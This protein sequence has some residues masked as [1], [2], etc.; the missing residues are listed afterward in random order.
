ME[1]PAATAGVRAR[2]RRLY[3]NR[4]A[5]VDGDLTIMTSK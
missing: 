4:Q 2:T 5:V 3:A 1:T